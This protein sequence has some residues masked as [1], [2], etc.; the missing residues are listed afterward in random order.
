[1]FPVSGYVKY[2][3]LKSAVCMVLFIRDGLQ[4]HQFQLIVKSH[5]SA[6]VKISYH[7][8][9]KH[10][11]HWC[12]WCSLVLTGNPKKERI[13][14][15]LIAANESKQREKTNSLCWFAVKPAVEGQCEMQ[16]LKPLLVATGSWSHNPL[17]F[18]PEISSQASKKNWYSR[19]DW[20]KEVEKDVCFDAFQFSVVSL[21]LPCLC[22][23]L[24]TISWL[25]LSARSKVSPG[26]GAGA[27]QGGGKLAQDCTCSA[28]LMATQEGSPAGTKEWGDMLPEGKKSKTL[29]WA[30]D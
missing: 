6:G 3:S 27:C 10:L 13:V 28:S 18:P 12:Y 15:K 30:T 2:F 9:G 29:K 22:T 17:C 21:L 26:S 24:E 23:M 14:K 7:S 4:C 8:C 16:W 1:M 5:S 19:H 11:R 25:G 20:E